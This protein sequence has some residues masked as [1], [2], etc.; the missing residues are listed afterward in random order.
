MNM[1]N[2]IIKYINSIPSYCCCP[3]CGTNFF[4]IKDKNIDAIWYTE[5]NGVSICKKCLSKPEKLD[6][7]KI[8]LNLITG[9]WPLSDL[10]MIKNSVKKL[11]PIKE[12][13]KQKLKKI[14]KLIN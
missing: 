14:S 13:R 2:K 8:Y 9:G 1:L 3:N 4:F 6:P 12:T 7:D 11:I 5:N 10:N